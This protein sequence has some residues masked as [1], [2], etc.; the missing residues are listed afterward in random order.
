MCMCLALNLWRRIKG[1]LCSFLA[2]VQ[3]QPQLPSREESL[4]QQVSQTLT[5]ATQTWGHELLAVD[6]RDL[7]AQTGNTCSM[8]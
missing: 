5:D 2:M 6:Q 8:D 3:T 1:G 4:P 7:H